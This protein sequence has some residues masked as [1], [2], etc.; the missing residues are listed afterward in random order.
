MEAVA[1]HPFKI[2][3]GLGED[4]G[5]LIREGNIIETIGSNLVIVVDGHHIRHNN[6]SYASVGTPLSIEN[7][8]VHVLAYGNYYNIKE[9]K[10]CHQSQE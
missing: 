1:T 5:V 9:R 7:L 8:L 3:I 2:G 10:F 4:T 6:T